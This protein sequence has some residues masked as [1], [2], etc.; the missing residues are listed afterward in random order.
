MASKKTRHVTFTLPFEVDNRTEKLPVSKVSRHAACKMPI[1]VDERPKRLP[2]SIRL[3]PTVAGIIVEV[4]KLKDDVA[5]VQRDLAVETAARNELHLCVEQLKVDN[6]ETKQ[7][8]AQA[9]NDVRNP[10]NSAKTLNLLMKKLPCKSLDELDWLLAFIANRSLQWTDYIKLIGGTDFNS[11]IKTIF[12]TVMERSVQKQLSWTGLH[13]KKPS[14]KFKYK[15]IVD[16]IHVAMKEQFKDYTIVRGE[17]KMQSL[18]KNA[19]QSS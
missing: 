14:L 4:R 8:M 17:A 5:Q 16:G 11:A 7:L 6:A 15:R 12:N 13:S 10:N 18:L 1:E 2:V 19:A 9:A 3:D